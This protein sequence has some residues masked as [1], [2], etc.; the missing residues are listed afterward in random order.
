VQWGS[1]LGYAMEGVLA[2]LVRHAPRR[3]QEGV[4]LA[5]SC[6]EPVLVVLLLHQPAHGLSSVGS[7]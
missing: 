3:V 4:L 2:M 1:A 5:G 6:G 7:P